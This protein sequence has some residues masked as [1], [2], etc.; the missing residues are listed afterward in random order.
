M[1]PSPDVLVHPDGLVGAP[2]ETAA[3]KGEEQHD[4]VIPL[5]PGAG[6]L[7]FVE[8]PVEVE[9]RGGKLVEDESGGVE[10][11]E[12]ALYVPPVSYQQVV[13]SSNRIA[14]TKEDKG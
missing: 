13:Y 10:V 9:E 1:Q 11:N 8:E 14:R 6:H 4:T 12:G 2:N 3:E 7:Q 5:R